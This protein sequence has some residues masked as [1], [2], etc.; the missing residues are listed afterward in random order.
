MCCSQNE[1]GA[2]EPILP[3]PELER[4]YQRILAQELVVNEPQPAPA[5]AAGGA[6]PRRASRLQGRGLAAAVGMTQM[7]LPFRSSLSPFACAW[8]LR[9]RVVHMKS[10]IFAVAGGRPKMAR[11][12]QEIIIMLQLAYDLETDAACEGP[13]LS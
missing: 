4:M 5:S 2:Y 1:H 13:V 3:V 6:R 11:P 7:T 10:R 12:S 9:G 8:R